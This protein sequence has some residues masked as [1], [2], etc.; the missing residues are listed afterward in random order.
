[1]SCIQKIN[2]YLIKT[3]PQLL[4]LLGLEKLNPWPVENSPQHLFRCKFHVCPI[5]LSKNP[6]FW[7]GRNQARANLVCSL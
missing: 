2:S 5:E 7:Y 1:M 4:E 6:C 3:E